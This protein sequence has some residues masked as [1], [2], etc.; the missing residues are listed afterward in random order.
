MTTFDDLVTRVR[1]Q[2]L[3]YAKDQLAVSELSAPMDADDTTF[4]V[5]T[6]TVGNLSTGLVEID[7]ELVLVRSYDPGSGVVQVMGGPNGRGAEGSTPA[8]H[9]VNALVNSDPRF[10][11]VRMKEAV[12]DAIRGVYPSLV[13]FG[14]AEIYNLSVVF[15]YG[16]PAEALDVWDVMDQTVGPT[17]VWMQ[18][19][20]YRFNP[21]ASPG[22]F[23]TGK[24]IQLFD[25][26]T[27]GRTMRIK[28]TKQPSP[29]VNGSDDFS[30]VS[31]LPDRVNDIIV[32][33]ACSRLLPAYESARLQQQAIEATERAPLV[34]P[35]SAVSVAAYYMQMYQQRLDQERALLFLEHPQPT[36]Y[37][38]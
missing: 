15:E 20:K 33:G 34:P 1:Q 6:G 11:R 22:S 5:D 7:D 26:I 23:P 3:G 32:W 24:S 29:L 21:S 18:G 38:S 4:T 35:K 36:Y 8:A 25:G 27:P 30:A 16:M 19:T 28:Y 37:G 2:I 17:Q 13:T 14:Y 12:N 10:P 9:G 31:G